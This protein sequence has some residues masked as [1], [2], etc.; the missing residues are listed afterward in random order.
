MTVQINSYCFTCTAFSIGFLSSSLIKKSVNQTP[1]TDQLQMNKIYSNNYN[2]NLFRLPIVLLLW[3]NWWIRARCSW[4][5]L[6]PRCRWHWWLRCPGGWLIV[7]SWRLRTIRWIGIWCG[8]CISETKKKHIVTISRQLA[9]NLDNLRIPFIWRIHCPV[10][11]WELSL[12]WW[13]LSRRCCW[14]ILFICTILIVTTWLSLV[15][16]T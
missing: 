16:S 3:W 12:R 9:F 8:R 13:I 7:W 10:W 11:W 1:N 6:C 5:I 14:S 15:W 2:T 4:R